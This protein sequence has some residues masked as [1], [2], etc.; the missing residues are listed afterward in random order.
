MQTHETKSSI[1]KFSSVVLCYLLLTIQGTYWWAGTKASVS[2]AAIK[3]SNYPSLAYKYY[4]F[5]KYITFAQAMTSS[6]LYPQ[7]VE[8][9]SAALSIPALLKGLFKLESMHSTT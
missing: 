6:V 5:L 1:I 7:V 9:A 4:K 2:Y 8:Q 3:C